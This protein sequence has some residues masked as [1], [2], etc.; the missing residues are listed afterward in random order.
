ME[1]FGEDYGDE[2][3]SGVREGLRGCLCVK[4]VGDECV[5]RKMLSVCV[6]WAYGDL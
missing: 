1:G 6:M 2:E 5:L 3:K 4:R